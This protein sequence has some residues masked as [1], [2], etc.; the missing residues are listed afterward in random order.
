LE[1]WRPDIDWQVW[2]AAVPG[3]NTSQEL[4]YLLEV[5]DRFQPDL[6]VVGFF[7]NDLSD[8]PSAPAARPDPRRRDEAALVCATPRVLSRVL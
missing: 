8:N 1:A 3:Y 6:V 7:D 5:G 2:N 4:A